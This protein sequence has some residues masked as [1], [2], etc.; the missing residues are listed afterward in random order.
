MSFICNLGHSERPGMEDRQ[1]TGHR[2][3]ADGRE[4]EHGHVVRALGRAGA[5]LCTMCLGEPEKGRLTQGT[6]T[7]SSRVRES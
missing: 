7:W 6:E 3:Q 2:P 4:R 1:Q 5:K